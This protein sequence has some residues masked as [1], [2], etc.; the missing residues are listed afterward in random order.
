M[1]RREWEREGFFS[2]PSDGS[3]EVTIRLDAPRIIEGTVICKDTEKPM[4][5][6][7]VGVVLCDADHTG[8]LDN[9][10]RWV[11]ADRNGRFRACCR[12]GEH[13]T[14]YV[15][16]PVGTP[17]PSWVE[18]STP[19]PSDALRQ[20]VTVELPRGLLVHGKVVE[21]GSGAPIA[22]A[23]VEYQLCRESSPYFGHLFACQIYWGAEYRKI[24]T[25]SDG[26]SKWR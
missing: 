5:Y 17:Y 13:L 8:D 6:A 26:R 24:V 20:E 12:P 2:I 22:G 25:G 4:G 7:W 23:G 11:K 16:P 21:A 3:E 18:D 10:A 1:T 9:R 19:W 15:F 14:I